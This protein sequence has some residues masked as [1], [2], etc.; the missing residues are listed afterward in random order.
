[1]ECKLLLQ[2]TEN[3]TGLGM[4]PLSVTHE[5][6]WNTLIDTLVSDYM[7]NTLWIKNLIYITIIYFKILEWYWRVAMHE[8]SSFFI[9]HKEEG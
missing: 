4:E 6:K 1:M 9:S 3:L 8:T 2:E 7:S 5:Y